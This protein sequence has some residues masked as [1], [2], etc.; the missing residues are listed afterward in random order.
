MKIVRF[1]RNDAVMY[2]ILDDSGVVREIS[3]Q[4]YEHFELT[5]NIYNLGE[6]NLLAPCEPSKVICVGLNYKAHVAE[7]KRDSQGLP[8]EPVL[9]MKPSTAVT[10]PG[11]GIV[12]PEMSAQVDYE[13]ELAV[14]I[15]RKAKNVAPEDVGGIIFGY[16]CANDVTARDLQRKDGQWTRA[17]GF[18]TFV[19]LGPWIETELDP[20]DR[21]IQLYLNDEVKQDSATA[22]MICP[23][24]QLVSFVSRVMTLLPGDVILT[25]TPEGVGPMKVGDQVK[26]VVDGIGGLSNPVMANPFKP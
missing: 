11:A 10:G 13:A 14:V 23:I 9:F 15:G 17:K 2:G 25:G 22:K 1:S 19:P 21:R 6:I 24:P 4:I 8:E 18:D 3:G 7:F 12:Y 26:V 20:S 5:G 16:T